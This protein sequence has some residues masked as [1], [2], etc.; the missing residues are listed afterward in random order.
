[1][2]TIK[3]ADANLPIKFGMFVLGT[4][5]RERGLKLSNLSQIGEDLL[6]ALEFTYAGVI[7]GYKAKGKKCPFTLEQFCDLVDKDITGMSR[8]VELIAGEIT[9]PED[10]EIKNVEAKEAS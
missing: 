2:K 9:A 6:M 4:F 1:M 10:E 5:L 3:I 7:A 8:I